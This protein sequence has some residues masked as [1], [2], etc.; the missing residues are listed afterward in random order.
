MP[1]LVVVIAPDSFKGSAGAAAVASAVAGGW[2]SARPDDRIVELPLADG[3]EGTLD[4]LE[5]ALS[6]C[7]RHE[8][9]VPG[10][11]GRPV[12]AS[13]L[14]LPDGTAVAELA[15]SSGLGLMSAPAPYDAHTR[16][17]GRVLVAAL[18]AGARRLVVGLGGSASTDG[19]AGLLTELGARFLDS[20]GEP[21]VDGSHGLSATARVDLSGLR[22]LPVGGVEIWSDVTAP[23]LG[24]DGTAAVFGPQ[25]G[26]TPDDVLALERALEGFAALVDVDP[27]TPGAGAAGGTGF[28]LLVWG[29]SVVA[30]AEAVA[31]AA[32][33][34]RLVAAADLVVT[35]EGRFDAQTAGGKL[36]SW[37]ASSAREHGVPVA[38]VAGQVTTSTIGFVDVVDVSVLAGGAAAS[39]ADPQ[40]WLGAAGSDLAERAGL[41][42]GAGDPHGAG[43]AGG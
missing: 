40:R 27:T 14:V 17:L 1:D 33:L 34:D 13:W 18:D 25:K 32:G 2:R 21:V 20:L 42:A 3:G 8:V 30:G 16:G 41:R 31:E 29:A 7:T 26:A 4:A 28:G 19:G 23:L 39:M 11:D 36:V 38:L 24:H 6:A 10:P 5:S 37:V 15:S 12:T 43:G 35:G 9:E 22:P